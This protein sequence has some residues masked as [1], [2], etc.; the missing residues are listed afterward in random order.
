MRM[1]LPIHTYVQ[2]ESMLRN[3]NYLLCNGSIISNN[4]ESEFQG[5]LLMVSEQIE[6]SH[7]LIIY[8]VQEQILLS[9]VLPSLTR[10]F[11]PQPGSEIHKKYQEE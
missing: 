7:I 3:V 10:I 4:S 2:K 1:N 9:R 11:L 8:K 5:K 6:K